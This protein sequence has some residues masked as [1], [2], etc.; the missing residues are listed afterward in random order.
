MFPKR[1]MARLWEPSLLG[2]WCS[3]GAVR[4]AT[5]R[6]YKTLLRQDGQGLIPVVQQQTAANAKRA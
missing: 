4:A 5:L 3:W 6:S 1:K 2:E